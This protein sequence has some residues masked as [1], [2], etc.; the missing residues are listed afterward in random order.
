MTRCQFID[1]PTDKPCPLR[2]EFVVMC[3][4]PGTIAKI[5]EFRL[6]PCHTQLV[7]D[8]DT[9]GDINLPQFLVGPIFHGNPSH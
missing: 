6:C 1:S 3:Q 7:L 4:A 9:E 5:L 2:A 8:L